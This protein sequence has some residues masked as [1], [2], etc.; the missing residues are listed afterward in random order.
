MLTRGEQTTLKLQTLTNKL[1]FYINGQ[2]VDSFQ[3]EPFFGNYLGF[4]VTNSQ[5]IVFSNLKICRLVEDESYGAGIRVSSKNF[6]NIKNLSVLFL[7]LAASSGVL[8]RDY[9]RKGAALANKCFSNGHIEEYSKLVAGDRYVYDPDKA[10]R[11][12]ISNVVDSLKQYRDNPAG[13]STGQLIQAFS[14]YPMEAK[15]YLNTRFISKPIQNIEKEVESSQTARSNS[16]TSAVDVGKFLVDVTSSDIEFLIAALGKGDYQ[17]Q[18]IAD[19]LANEVI[20]CGI[21]Y[22]NATRNDEPGLPLYQYGSRVAVSP[23]TQ[24]KA[25]E[26][27]DSC[28]ATLKRQTN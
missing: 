14:G 13:I 21:D 11:F 9:L 1:S 2:F 23:R 10:L 3:R 22:F 18:S 5:T 17:Y 4:K 12:Y 16:P 7:S 15:Q 28:Q 8:R 6:S 26:N 24:Q 25:K 20:Q 27:L 19:K